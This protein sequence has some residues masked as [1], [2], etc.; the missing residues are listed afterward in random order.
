MEAA[1]EMN[2]VQLP[3]DLTQNGSHR[4][5]QIWRDDNAAVY[6]QFGQSDK[7]IGYEIFVIKKQPAC[8]MFDKDY[9]AK[10]LYPNSEEWGNLAWSRNDRD[11]ALELGCSLSAR[12]DKGDFKARLGKP[13]KAVSSTGGSQSKRFGAPGVS[14]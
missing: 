1:T 14:K 7:L 3:R 6:E 13:Q 12:C 4:Y 9:P 11:E 2:Y 5:H 8:R 10:E